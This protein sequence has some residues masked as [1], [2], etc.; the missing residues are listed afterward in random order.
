LNGN[1]VTYTDVDSYGLEKVKPVY[2]WLT[3]WDEEISKTRSFDELP[4]NARDFV[5]MIEEIANAPVKWIGVGPER[6]A[7]IRR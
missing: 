2:T 3:G 1:P 6:E 5:R 4:K 7:T